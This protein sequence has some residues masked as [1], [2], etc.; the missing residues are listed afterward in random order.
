MADF[1]SF[2][3]NKSTE[4]LWQWRGRVEYA[5]ENFAREIMQLF[6]I[7]LRKIN[8]DGTPIIGSDGSPILTYTID[9]I[10]EYAKV[11]TGE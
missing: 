9:E 1:L 3:D 4:F 6:T 10:T 2:L 11:W 7:G 5:D 8:I